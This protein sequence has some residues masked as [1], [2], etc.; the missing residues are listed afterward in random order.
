MR[1]WRIWPCATFHE[2]TVAARTPDAHQRSTLVWRSTY[3]RCRNVEINTMA[4]G[5]NG[6]PSCAAA[7]TPLINP[8]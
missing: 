1:G 6:C 5:G 7:G 3:S 4:M 2:E 8:L